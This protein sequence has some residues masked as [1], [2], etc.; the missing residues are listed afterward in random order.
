MFIVCRF[1]T[2]VMCERSIHVYCVLFQYKGDV[3]EI[4]PRVMCERSIHVYCVLFQYR[5]DV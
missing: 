5:G 4:N 2:I 1:N 3:C